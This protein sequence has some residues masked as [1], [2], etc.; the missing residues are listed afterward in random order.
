GCVARG[1]GRNGCDARYRQ[2]GNR[3]A[4]PDRV[5]GIAGQGAEARLAGGYLRRSGAIPLRASCAEAG[6]KLQERG[7]NG[8]GAWR[9]PV[10]ALVWET[11][12]RRFKSSRSDQQ[13]QALGGRCTTPKQAGVTGRVTALSWRRGF[14]LAN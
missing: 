13:N 3:P 11:R 1:G 6:S 14:G 7:R 12:G 4:G 2:A 9:S 8:I 10:S 5:P